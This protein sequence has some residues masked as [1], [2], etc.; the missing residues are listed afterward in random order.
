MK[1]S[2]PLIAAILAS[3]AV[4]AMAQTVQA[5]PEPYRLRLGEWSKL[6]HNDRMIIVVGAI[7][8]LLLA[9]QAPDTGRA[10]VNEQCLVSDSPAGIE[11]KLLK[12]KDRYKNEAFVDVF[13]VA[14]NCLESGS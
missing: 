8:G 11:A 2:K 5:E 12:V 4:P 3:I 10:P 6:K 14:T 13:L 9:V 1:K 7:E